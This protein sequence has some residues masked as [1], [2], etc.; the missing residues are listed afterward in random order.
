M[1]A[2]RGSVRRVTR[3]ADPAGT[4]TGGDSGELIPASASR[5]GYAA[6]CAVFSNNSTWPSRNAHLLRE[7]RGAHVR[8]VQPFLR[9]EVCVNRMKDLGLNKALKSPPPAPK[10]VTMARGGPPKAM[11]TLRRVCGPA[12]RRFG[13]S[14]L[15]RFGASAEPQLDAERYVSA[16]SAGDLVAGVLKQPEPRLRQSEIGSRRSIGFREFLMV[17]TI[18]GICFRSMSKFIG[19]N[20]S[21][22]DT[23]LAQRKGTAKAM[24][25]RSMN[26]FGISRRFGRGGAI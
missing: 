14:A 10:G 17:T 12:L 9:G 22:S 6:S 18:R 23:V 7:S 16:G 25:L 13:A 26:F 1:P 4:R 11:K 2:A 21:S 24:E 15:R 5:N 20:G 8:E 19:W 3:R